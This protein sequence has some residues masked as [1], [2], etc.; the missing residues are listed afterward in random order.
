LGRWLA[1]LAGGMLLVFVISVVGIA[2]QMTL[3]N[4]YR[5]LFGLPGSARPLFVLPLL[6]LICVALMLL[7]AFQAW[8]RGAGSALGR[9]YFTLLTL[10]GIACV[11]VLGAWGAIT[12][13]FMG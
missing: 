1:V 3:S 7:G 4:D 2:V 5:I 13:L 9:V 6:S 8:G 11:A 12:A 10:A